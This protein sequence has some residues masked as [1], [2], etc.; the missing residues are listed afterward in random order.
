M[1]A[2]E[3]DPAPAVTRALRILTVLAENEGVPLTLSEI[4][5]A[6]DIAKSSAAN[7]CASLGEGGMIAR[8]ARGYRLGRRTAELGGAF[9]LQFNQIREFFAICADSEVLRREVVQIAMLDGTDALYLARHEGRG[10]DRLGTPLGSRLPAAQ[11]ATGRAALMP[12]AD[13]EI[14]ER[15]GGSALRRRT[16]RSVTSMADLLHV[17]AAAR[18][19]GYAIDDSAALAGVAGIA[20]PLPPW[21]PSDP[22]FAMGVAL[23]FAELADERAAAIG[24][25]L[26]AAAALLTNPLAERGSTAP[27]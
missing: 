4:A 9:A 24:E 22:P 12:F 18:E 10:Q 27:R 7:L 3:R 21:S 25:A 2:T 5:R 11:T 20:V 15:F 17:V 16:E 19:R 8:D 13:E 6:L 26:L 14:R 23:P 1:T